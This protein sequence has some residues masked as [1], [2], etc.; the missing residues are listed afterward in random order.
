[1]NKEL[2]EKLKQVQFQKDKLIENLEE[3]VKILSEIEKARDNRINHLIS[4]ND[5]LCGVIR[6]IQACC[7]QVVIE[8][9]K[10]G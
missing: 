4:N 3:Q 7:D 10:D 9:K 8:R 1:M 5:F 6:V 2:T